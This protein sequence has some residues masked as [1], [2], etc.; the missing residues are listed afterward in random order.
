L[1]DYF[2]TDTKR[3]QAQAATLATDVVAQALFAGAL[4]LL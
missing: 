2:R 3:V 4:E 1:F